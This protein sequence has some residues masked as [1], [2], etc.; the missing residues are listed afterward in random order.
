MKRTTYLMTIIICAFHLA[1]FSQ[2]RPPNQCPAPAAPSGDTRCYSGPGCLDVSFNTTGFLT[3]A[4]AGTEDIGLHDITVQADGKMVGVGWIDETT[5]GG[6]EGFVVR[7]NADGSLDTTFGDVDLSNPLLRRG[8]ISDGGMARTVAIQPDGR[9]VVGGS[10][11]TGGWTII[12]YMPDGVRDATFD[13]DGIVTAGF[14]L[15]V[16]DLAIQSDGKILAAGP[17]NFTVLRLNND[18]SRDQMFGTNGVVSVNPSSTS[19]GVGSAVSVAIQIVAG[20]ELIVLGGSGYDASTVKQRN[21]AKEKYMLMRLSPT[22][23]IDMSFGAS[24]RVSTSFFDHTDRVFS[25]AIDSQNR[26]VAAGQSGTS[27]CDESTDASFAR[28]SG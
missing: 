3:F 23:S 8:Y 24:G 13:N 9:I 27:T 5:S 20:Q 22:G 14:G 1:M 2:N 16:Q 25:I 19:L 7:F 21:S 15:F 11:P 6:S 26:I 17:S 18:G 12:R 28:Y 10:F 4:P